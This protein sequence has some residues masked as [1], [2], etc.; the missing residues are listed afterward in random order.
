[1]LSVILVIIIMVCIILMSL[2]T[3]NV[4]LLI[5]IMLHV[6]LQIADMLTPLCCVFF[7]ECHWARRY[8]A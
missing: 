3:L 4:I 2:A 1:M 8:S 7:A 5:I 6:F